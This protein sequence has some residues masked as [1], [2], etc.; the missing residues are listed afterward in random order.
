MTVTIAYVAVHCKMIVTNLF[1]FSPF[2]LSM[3]NEHK[4]EANLIWRKA[5]ANLTWLFWEVRETI[6]VETEG[7][8]ISFQSRLSMWFVTQRKRL[9]VWIRS[10]NFSTT[11]SDFLKMKI[12]FLIARK[13][14]SRDMRDGDV[15]VVFVKSQTFHMDFPIVILVERGNAKWAG[16][17]FVC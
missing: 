9:K 11:K 5:S 16:R 2:Q 10:E 13:K 12:F 1:R 7:K 17:Y 3:M 14:L 15:S 6:G 8:K 4:R